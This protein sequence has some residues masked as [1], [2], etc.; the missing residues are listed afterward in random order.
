M[1]LNVTFSGGMF[2]LLTGLLQGVTPSATLTSRCFSS[3]F[4]PDVKGR[5]TRPVV[6]DWLAIVEPGG[7]LNAKPYLTFR[8]VVQLAVA[9]VVAVAVGVVV[10]VAVEAGV[11]VRVAVAGVGACSVGVAEGAAVPATLIATQK[12]LSKVVPI[13]N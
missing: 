11:A 2:G 1:P 9:E 4:V 8:Y 6:S 10:A 5:Y 13:P 7:T 3:R 12:G